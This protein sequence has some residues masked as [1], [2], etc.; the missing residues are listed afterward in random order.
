MALAVSVG[1]VVDDAI[2]M[3]E[4]TF[5]GLEKGHSPLR[6]AIEGASQIGFTVVAIS[7]S[8]IVAFIPLLFMGGV[9]GR[10]FRE[11]SVTLAVAIAISM[12]VSLTVTPM[13][14]AHFIREAPRSTT[15]FDHLVE[16]AL[17][18]MV[19]GYDRTLA[20]ALRHNVVTLMVFVATI[21]ATAILYVKTPKGYFPQDDTG[22]I[23]GGSWSS[24]DVS[25]KTMVD[26][27]REVNKIVAED[28]AVAGIGSSVGGNSYSGA[29]NAGTMFISLKPLAERGGISA[30]ASST[31]SATR[32]RRCRT[33]SSGW[34]RR[35]ICASAA[36][37]GQSQY[38]F[39]LW[40]P[41][42]ADLVKW[43]PI[44]RDRIKLLDGITDVSSDRDRSGLQLGIS[45]DR[46]RASNLGV[47]MQAIDSALSNAFA[48]RQISTI[49]SAR[50]QYRVILE[51]D[52]QFQRDPSDMS[53]VYVPG[54]G[55]AAVPLPAVAKFARG[56]APLAVDASGPVSGGDGL[57]R[58]CARICRWR[59][60]RKAFARRS[61]NC[62][63]PTR[64]APISPATRAH[65]PTQ[66]TRRPF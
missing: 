58:A 52:P 12:V 35:R 61:P 39:T 57:V 21:A 18:W 28:P 30:S 14:C 45:I 31:A 34:C 1:F 20:I 24:N 9:V 4:N 23:I 26:L 8:L 56:Q 46:A 44:V 43:A 42:L 33:C 13:V 50:N 38:Q 5:R 48:Q 3:I 25:F 60:E 49:Y 32:S 19:R 15:R 10:L 65:S 40:S 17:A 11:F 22:L 7:I 63:C 53:Q 6:A 41:D 2:V 55:G 27:H 64:S 59:R 47:K 36:V 29:V 51:I 16:G 37:K 66:P 62:T 54:T